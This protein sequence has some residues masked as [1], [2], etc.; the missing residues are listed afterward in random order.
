MD[1]IE[2]PRFRCTDCPAGDELDLCEQCLGVDF[3]NGNHV[4]SHRFER[5]NDVRDSEV[6]FK[7]EDYSWY[8]APSKS[9]SSSR[10]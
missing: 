7:D 8:G 1:P 10:H 9:N 3:E 6:L 5:I 2:G 4:K